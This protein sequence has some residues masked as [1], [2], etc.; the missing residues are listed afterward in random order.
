MVV[1]EFSSIREY[2]TRPGFALEDLDCAFTL[3]FSR[4]SLSF[5]V[6]V[7]YTVLEWFVE[8]ADAGAG[9]R[10]ED[11]ADYTAYDKRPREELVAEMIA[12]LHRLLRALTT[13]QFRLLKGATRLSPSD[14]CEWR[15]GGKW[16]A[17]N[18]GDT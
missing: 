12:H 3:S 8:I 11:W 7:A 18:Y 10:F 14:R 5:K 4:S 13:D 16:T 6:T 17:F 15:V 9:L 2:G 1:S